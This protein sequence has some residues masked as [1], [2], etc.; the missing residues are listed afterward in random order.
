MP[1]LP[2]ASRRENHR[3]DGEVYWRKDGTAFP[4]EYVSRPVIEGGDVKGAVVTFSDVGERKVAEEKLRESEER[5]RQLFDQSV[6]ALLV[7]DEAGRM[8]YC[9]EEACRSLGYSRE[10]LLSLSV[11]DFATNLLSEDEKRVLRGGTLWERAAASEPGGGAE[12]VHHGEHRRKDG[13]TFPVEVHVGTVNYGNRPMILASARDVTERNRAEEKLRESEERFRS[14]VQNASDLITV[15]AADGTVLYESPAIEG[16][17]GYGPEDLIG[18]NALDLIH[19]DDAPRV[20]RAFSRLSEERGANPYVEYRFRRADGSW[21]H[22]ESSG[23]NLLEEPSVGGIVVNTRDVT[24]RK[25]LE[26]RLK[27][28]ALHDPLTG[29]PNRALLLDRLGHALD[30]ADR[31]EACVAVLFLD[32]DDFKVVN[33]SLGHEAGDDLLVAAARRLETCLRPGDTLAR[34][35]G[36]EFVVLLEDVGGRGEAT[37]VATRIAE[38]LR[39]PFLLGAHEEA[40]VSVSIGVALTSGGEDRTGSLPDDLLRWADVAMYDAKRKGKAHHA[41]FD[42][43]MDA[44]ALERLRLGAD[45]RRAAER[46][47]FRV[48]YQ[49][50]VELS[51]GRVVGFEALMRWEHPE[52]GLV[53]PGRFIPVAEETGMIIPIGRWVLEEACRQAKKWCE[54]RP[55]GPP[56]AMSVNLSARQFAHPDLARDVARALG[57]SGLDPGCLVLEITESA[58]MEDARSTIDTLEELESLGVGLAIDDFGT[59]YSSLSYLRRFP[60]D[61]LKI[62]RSFVDGIEE[63]SGDAVLVSGIVDL[64]HALGLSV[65]AEG[66]ETEGQLGLLRG[67]GCDLAQGY[68]F[69]R[70]MPGEEADTLLE[71][72][73]LP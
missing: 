41:V 48:H 38:A 55:N 14:L 19:P 15:L 72:A 43:S 71:K 65:V 60:V 59:G 58:V 62:D 42:P 70:P 9:N 31:T 3:T 64:A 32:L 21:R 56:L 28:Q 61:Y 6:D 73:R 40:F 16:M 12:G 23:A 49:P 17:L 25:T 26:E 7:H 18:K 29:L 2:G 46:G 1:Q 20:M 36:D 67:M 63:D 10:E 53:P 44:R 34:L 51:T 24:E 13:T 35:G 30:R 4:V 47:E 68:H 66:V 45:L 52:Q 39:E 5:F 11:A 69:S 37:G 54:G 27:H 57:E 8:V 22:L 50:E 33:D